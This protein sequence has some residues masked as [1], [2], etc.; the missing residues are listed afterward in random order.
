MPALSKEKIKQ[1]LQDCDRKL[2]PII[3]TIA[4]PVTRRNKDVYNALLHSIV[5]QQLSVKAAA[6]IHA[7][8]LDL[9]SNNDAQPR[10]LLKMPLSKLRGAGLSKQKAGYLKAIA[11]FAVEEGLVYEELSKKNNLELIEHLTQIKGVGHW[12][13][14]MLLMFI[15]NRK[16]VFPIADVGI[17]NA[18]R[19]LYKLDEDGKAFKIKLIELAEP[20][21]PYRTIVCKYLWK[22]KSTG[23]A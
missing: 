20:W 10:M 19:R 4:Y 11:K 2:I 18:M 3:N 7:R 23:Y 8:V 1:Y 15:F 21:Q 22:W 17:Q 6:T 13:V 14:E 16:D 12:T 9:F 5:S